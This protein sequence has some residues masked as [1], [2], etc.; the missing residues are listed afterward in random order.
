MSR[1]SHDTATIVPSPTDSEIRYA[2]I[3]NDPY[4]TTSQHHAAIITPTESQL[5][6]DHA[7]LAQIRQFNESQHE[8]IDPALNHDQDTA[9]ENEPMGSQNQQESFQ[10][11]QEQPPSHTAALVNQHRVLARTMSQ[12]GNTGTATD[13][14]KKAKKSG[15]NNNA[16]NEKELRELIETNAHRS[17]EAIA[18][19][20]RSAEK[21][22]KAEKAKQLFAM[23]W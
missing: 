10:S 18:R 22:Q 6:G 12:D 7:S 21:T 16:A 17:L 19:D 15:N 3:N 11:V 5:S 13:E 9:A 2:P 4:P 14:E 8:I 1:T 20:V 23:R